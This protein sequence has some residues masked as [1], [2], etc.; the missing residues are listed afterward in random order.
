MANQPLNNEYLYRKGLINASGSSSSIPSPIVKFRLTL[1]SQN[2]LFNPD[3]RDLFNAYKSLGGANSDGGTSFIL[4]A[5]IENFEESTEHAITNRRSKGGFVENH[6]GPKPSVVS[7]TGKVGVFL[8]AL[9]LTPLQTE[10]PETVIYWDPTSPVALL[11]KPPSAAPT[12]NPNSFTQS[13]EA[14]AN[15]ALSYIGTNF[16]SVNKVK[17][18]TGLNQYPEVTDMGQIAQTGINGGFREFRKILDLFKHNGLVFDSI[19]NPD[20]FPS[21]YTAG[22]TYF[23]ASGKKHVDPSLVNSLDPGAADS[24]LQALN[25]LRLQNIAPG[26]VRA[27]LPIEM[28]IRDTVYT[29]FFQNFNYSLTEESPYTAQYD[30]TFMAKTTTRTAYFFKNGSAGRLPYSMLINPNKPPKP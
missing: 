29:G 5:L 7:I 25:R 20:I 22:N 13:V 4:Y 3:Y 24:M 30:F 1:P 9:G 18:P 10:T 23:D 6:W 17:T 19:P 26:N 12:T 27:V 2:Y 14:A 16:T 28:F 11:S 15:K 8:S 21:T